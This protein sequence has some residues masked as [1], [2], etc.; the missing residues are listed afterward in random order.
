VQVLLKTSSVYCIYRIIYQNQSAEQILQKLQMDVKE[1]ND[2]R[3]AVE[4]VVQ[5]REMHLEKLQVSIFSQCL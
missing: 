5:D 4:K 3:E 2:K 1:I